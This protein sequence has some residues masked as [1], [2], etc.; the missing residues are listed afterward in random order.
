MKKLAAII[1][2]SVL[3]LV[4]VTPALAAQDVLLDKVDFSTAGGACNVTSGSWGPTT[5]GGNYGGK[6][7]DSCLVWESGA[8]ATNVAEYTL[9]TPQGA[10]KKLTIRHLDGIADDSFSVKV[11]HANGS[12]IPVGSYADK[13]SA[14]IWVET[15][16]DLTGITLGRGRDIP[17]SI[18]ATG[19][20]WVELGGR[21][22]WG[23]LAIDWMKLW[24]NGR[25]R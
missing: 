20:A 3:F 8:S 23:Q 9:L 10:A 19:P 2:F 4:L 15:T 5:V 21:E 22:K 13:S 1:V 11:Q 6:Q 24:G 16:F 18:T 7:A 14:E 12:W 17:V 25:P